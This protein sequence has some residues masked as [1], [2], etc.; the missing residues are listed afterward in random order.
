M[1]NIYISKWKIVLVILFGVLLLGGVR[2]FLMGY[3][4]NDGV[5]VSFKTQEVELVE[6][7]HLTECG[8]LDKVNTTYYLD[9]NI[10]SN[11][12]CFVVEAD[13]VVLD[14]SGYEVK[15][16]GLFN[17][18]VGVLSDVGFTSVKNCVINN[19][20]IGVYFKSNK[21]G[22]LLDNLLEWNREGIYLWI[23]KDNVV[24]NNLVNNNKDFGVHLRLADGNIIEGNYLKGDG[25]GIYLSSSNGNKI[26]LNE[27]YE[28]NWYG[29][30]LFK[31]ID[32]LVSGNKFCL[33]SH[34]DIRVDR[35]EVMDGENNSC[36]SVSYFNDV[37]VV[38]CSLSC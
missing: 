26:I 7:E 4:S 15:D 23:S 24:R 10:E 37:G 32:N 8:V 29:V 1:L 16:V 31:S 38:G 14:C 30:Y 22:E 11:G 18:S 20:D 34:T 17:D 13:N 36:E 9:K 5:D 33:N 12:S 27:G 2:Y 35:G 21:G 25:Y 6:G 19:F 28:N 3:F